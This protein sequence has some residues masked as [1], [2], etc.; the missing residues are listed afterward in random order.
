[1]LPDP[2]DGDFNG[3]DLTS[4]LKVMRMLLNCSKK[5]L[6]GTAPLTGPMQ[7]AP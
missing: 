2:D 5:G 3:A 7:T 1:M 4:R 6:L